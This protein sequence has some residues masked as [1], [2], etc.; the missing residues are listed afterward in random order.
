MP[1]SAAWAAV[2]N[3]NTATTAR[4]ATKPSGACVGNKANPSPRFDDAEAIQ[5]II[6]PRHLTTGMKRG[7]LKARDRGFKKTVR[8]GRRALLRCGRG[9]WRGRRAARGRGGRRRGR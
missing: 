3:N 4:I 2:T 6:L 8:S 9:G 5:K 7:V 1:Q